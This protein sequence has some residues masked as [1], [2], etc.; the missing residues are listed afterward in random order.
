MSSFFPTQVVIILD[1]PFATVQKQYTHDLRSHLMTML[2]TPNYKFKGFLGDDPTNFRTNFDNEDDMDS[3]VE[4][5]RTFTYPCD[6]KIDV[7]RN[8]IFVSD[9]SPLGI[10]V[11]DLYTKSFIYNIKVNDRARFMDFYYNFL[12][13]SSEDNTIH[14]FDLETQQEVWA[15]NGETVSFIAKENAS[16]GAMRFNNP[17]GV[18]CDEINQEIYVADCNNDRIVKIS[19]EDGGFI[20]NVTSFKTRRLFQEMDSIISNPYGIDMDLAGN[21]VVTDVVGSRVHV[22]STTGK[23]LTSFGSHGRVTDATKQPLSFDFPSGVLVDRKNG[24]LL[25]CD[26]NNHR[27][28]VMT[29]LGQFVKMFGSAGYGRPNCFSYPRGLCIDQSSGDLYVVDYDNNR[30]QIFQQYT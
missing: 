13:F 14:K 1:A 12:I 22:M 8:L 6:V 16:G 23:I 5:R 20:C 29:S 26:R 17:C 30:I 3:Y 21:L 11:F 4:K 7:R 2:R 10:Q 28:Q 27:V 15:S 18:V 25:V 19:G 9:C 24:N